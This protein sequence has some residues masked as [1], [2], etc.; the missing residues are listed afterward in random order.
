MIQRIQTIY[1]LAVF[2]LIVQVF[3]FPFLI[4]FNEQ[5]TIEF[6]ALRIS[7]GEY[8]IPLTILYG[9]ILLITLVSIFLFKHRL[10]QARLTVINMFLLFGSI[11]LVA[12]Y[13]WEMSKSLPTHDIKYNFTC[14]FPILAII[15][16]FLALKGIQKDEALVRSA[17]RLRP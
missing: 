12:Y 13:G 3:I 9:V 15:F 16:N 7:N 10:V 1:L 2:V 11:G 6:S 8:L 17:N 4:F 5:E 14:L